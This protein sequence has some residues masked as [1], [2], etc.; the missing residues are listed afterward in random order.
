MWRQH[1]RQSTFITQTL[2]NI[3]VSYAFCGTYTDGIA[4]KGNIF[5]IL[6]YCI[7]V[8]A[9]DDN[10]TFLVYLRQHGVHLHLK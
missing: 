2:G 7:Y 8:V 10:R 6:Q 3:V 4:D 1:I 5:S 9:Y